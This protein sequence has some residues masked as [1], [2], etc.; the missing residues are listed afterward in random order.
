MKLNLKR[1]LNN[2]YRSSWFITLFATTLGV[3]L[4]LYL[5]N[6]NSRSKIE[7]RKQNSIQNIKKELLNNTS[8]LTDSKVN[9]RLI[10]FLNKLSDI[11]NKIPNILSTSVNSINYLRNNYPDL[12]QIIDS[13]ITGNNLIEYNVNYR[14]VLDLKDLQNIAWETAKMSNVTNEID[15]DCLQSLVKI[16]TLQEIFIKEQQKIL[17][18]IINAEHAKLRSSLLIVQQLESRLLESIIEGQEEFKNCD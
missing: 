1:K 14:F 15:Y 3:L 7:N 6:L 5:N 10:F 9:D 11:D 16:Y 8:E 17:N 4:A 18:H 2:L 12:I 13:T